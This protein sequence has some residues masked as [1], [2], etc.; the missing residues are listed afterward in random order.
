MKK[1]YRYSQNGFYPVI[2][3]EPI[4]P[5]KFKKPLIIT[6]LDWLIFVGLGL[7]LIYVLSYVSGLG[8]HTWVNWLISLI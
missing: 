5:A 2:E 1:Y 4:K 7:G 3:H 6:L 8:F